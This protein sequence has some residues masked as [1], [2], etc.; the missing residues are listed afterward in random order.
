MS[1]AAK[2]SFKILGYIHPS[3][4]QWQAL[5]MSTKLGVDLI[6]QSKSGTGK[7]IIYVVTSLNMIN[8]DSAAIQ[9]SMN[10]SLTIRFCLTLRN[11]KLGNIRRR[12]EGS[13]SFAPSLI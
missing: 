8:T 10:R 12:Y 9:V 3:A 6:V 4:I 2:C 11:F 7:T 5:P 13:S 1:S